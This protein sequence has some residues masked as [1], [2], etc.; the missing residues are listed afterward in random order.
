MFIAGMWRYTWPVLWLERIIQS[1]RRCSWHKLLVYGWLRGQRILQCWNV[2]PSISIKGKYLW[3]QRF[4]V[5]ILSDWD[6]LATLS[7]DIPLL[8]T[9][10]GNKEVKVCPHVKYDLIHENTSPLEQTCTGSPSLNEE[11]ST[12]F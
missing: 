6:S 3:M 11:S 12:V 10:T 9:S 1:W 7:Y 8:F 5:W 4:R 2:P